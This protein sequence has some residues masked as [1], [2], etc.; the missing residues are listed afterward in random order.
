M[1]YINVDEVYILD[2]TGLQ[3]DQVTDIP[4]IDAALTDGQKA[5]ARAN[6]GAGGTNPNLLDNPF[7]QV[8]Q[9]QTTTTSSAN[10]YIADRWVVSGNTYTFTYGRAAVSVTNANGSLAYLF[11][12]LQTEV[13]NDIDGKTVTYSVKIDGVVHSVSFVWDKTLRN[14]PI[15]IPSLNDDMRFW[16]GDQGQ[17]CLQIRVSGTWTINAIKLELGSVSTLAND[18]PPNYAEELAKCQHYLYA[19]TFP[20][21]SYTGQICFALD[22]TNINWVITTPT[23]M[24]Q[25]K[26]PSVTV[27]NSLY[28]NGVAISNYAIVNYPYGNN[29]KV[30]AQAGGL[31]NGQL[32][33]ITTS[34]NEA[35]VLISAEL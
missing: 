31:T 1:P 8:N 27:T 20:G 5:Q 11:Q 10:A 23:P 25:D 13:Y 29:V 17:P 16:Y 34:A 12:K 3:V 32:Y 19:V 9:R 26:L 22:T 7:F 21:Y 28:A 30:S 2:N 24:V 18:L 35:K 33:P 6:I 14:S 4:Y 15:T